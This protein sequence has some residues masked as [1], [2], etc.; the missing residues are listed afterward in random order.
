MKR[1]IALVALILAA[2][3]TA[4]AGDVAT[5]VNLGFSPDSA[6][7]MFGFHGL[8]TSNGKP[9]AELY[10]VDTK[11]NDFVPGGVFK[12]M[13]GAELR[14]GWDPAGGFYKLFSD[15]TPMARKYKIDHLAQGRLVY[16]L[17][18]G[19][20]GADALSFKDFETGAQWDVAIK[21]T[22]EEKS[23]TVISSFG[24]EASIGSGDKKTS[25]K[26]GNPGIR[27]R[28]VSDYA[29]K[30]IIVAP[31]GK[32]VVAIIERREKTPSG[33]AIRY[34]VETFRLP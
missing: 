6:Y 8:D 34:M 33:Q 12:G 26:A 20:P 13:Y 10:L 3:G 18:N 25:L 29:I 31:D 24:L 2:V 32:T 28:G 23:G 27:R 21:K 1:R 16:L 14:P 7:F 17:I 19:E 9:Y 15:A 22:I 30:E 5:L 4:F 11:K